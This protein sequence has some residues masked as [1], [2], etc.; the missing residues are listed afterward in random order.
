MRITDETRLERVKQA[1][2]RIIV[3]K[4]YYG[5]TI[6]NIANSAGVSTGYLYRHYKNKA[7]LVRSLFVENKRNFHKTLFDFLDKSNTIEEFLHR[8]CQY[9]RQTVTENPEIIKF[10]SLLTHDYN[11]KF[12]DIIKEEVIL[13]GNKIR[14]K[15]LQ[16]GEISPE[17]EVEEILLSFFGLQAKLL[18]MAEKGVISPKYFEEM[19]KQRIISMCL[20]LWR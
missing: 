15:G 5:T 11:F 9:I 8:S 16:T 6:S 17:T 20:K 13:I 2:I 14:Q 1:T 7:D 12:P 3:E 18:D 10:Y 4:G 19:A